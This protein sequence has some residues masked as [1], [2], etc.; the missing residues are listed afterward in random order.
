MKESQ[1]AMYSE[2]GYSSLPAILS[3]DR[4]QP[5]HL[6]DSGALY[7]PESMFLFYHSLFALFRFSTWDFF[8][9][10]S[11]LDPHAEHQ[12]NHTD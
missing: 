3:I 11:F 5:Q 4:E 10:V 8:L 12:N 7:N 9:V 6:T 2:M 1:E